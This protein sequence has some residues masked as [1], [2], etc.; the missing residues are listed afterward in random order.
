MPA[1]ANPPANA[2]TSPAT[3]T[4]PAHPRPIRPLHP[5]APSAAQPY[6][7]PMPDQRPATP[8]GGPVRFAVVG[9]GWRSRFFLRLAAMAPERLECVSAL[10][11]RPSSADALSRE[12]G[13]P[14][15]TSLD[16]LLRS[17]P[18]VVAPLVGWAQM[19]GLIRELV[20]AGA[21]VLA[22]T[23]PAP[24]PD[25]LRAL[26]NDVGATGLVQV[27]EQY[28]LVPTHAARLAALADSP[29]GTPSWAHLSSTH[30]YHAV[31]LLRRYLSPDGA[32]LAAPV[33]VTARS[34]PAALLQPLGR[35]GWEASP[36]VVPGETTLATLAFADGPTG[37]Y[38]FTS[39]QWHNPLLSRRLL[40]RG[41]RGELVDDTLTR[42]VDGVGP[43][44]SRIEYRHTGT[45]LN[46]EGRD[47]IHATLDGR[48]LYRNPWAGTAMSD[49]DLAVATILEQA[50][51]WARGDGP[52][53]YPLAEACQDHL[54]SCAIDE[55]A[56]T[57]RDVTTAVEPWSQR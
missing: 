50:G 42:W 10:V 57:G 32:A 12:F 26:W 21:R 46:L 47:L 56:R 37:V 15:A 2:A 38:E 23:P 48:L 19:P 8:P 52:E 29:I 30:G 25:S 35:D 1:T 34:R 55:A 54:I 53:P 6:M 11:R 33:T 41:T 20:A 44:T 22:E 45:D 31:A 24:D 16:E 39:N 5:L 27:A 36:A 9:A 17:G 40:V 28:P 13:V 4:S 14:T 18:E 3:S 51:A 49:D 7:A 43:V